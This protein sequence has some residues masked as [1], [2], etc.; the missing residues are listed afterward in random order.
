M[1][2]TFV[3]PNMEWQFDHYSD[4]PLGML[5]VASAAKNISLGMDSVNVSL[6]DMCHDTECPESDVYAFSASTLE[7]PTVVRVA[8][9]ISK[10]NPH[11][12]FIA[13]GPHFDVLS[14]DYWNNEIIRTPF[15]VIS[16]GEGE[17]N[18]ESI[19]RHV[20]ERPFEKKVFSQ[21]GK[22]LNLDSL[23]LPSRNL[24]DKDLYF[25]PGRTFGG[26]D[27]HEKSIEGN[28]S[29]I[30]V[31]RGC[32]YSC[33]F[34]AS[35]TLHRGRVRFRDISKVQEE[36][37][38]LVTDYSV[39]QLRWQDDNIP[40]NFK[41][42]KGLGNILRDFGIISRGSARTDTIVQ[43]PLILNELYSAGF[44]ELGFGIESADQYVL[45]LLDKR[46][47]LAINREALQRAKDAGF[48]T[49]A[50]IMTGL[51]GEDEY[52][53]E[54]MIDFFESLRSSKPDVVTLTSFMPLPGCDIFTNPEKYGIKILSK[55]WGSYSI[56]LS[57][58][59]NPQWT[60]QIPN[61]TSD[62]MDLNREKLKE[63]LFNNNMSNVP[64]YNKPYE[65]SIK[66]DKGK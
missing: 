23:C 2:L 8:E 45:N 10:Q 60:H 40:L 26:A 22:L 58:D 4:P 15:N 62:Q 41:K 36:L 5:S 47:N 51:P 30:M 52:S 18:I 44:R 12:S 48:I 20:K 54:R 50:F 29:T 32:P 11:A 57:R 38:M 65:S 27:S 13:G 19:L 1:D 3:L 28:S 46:T 16:R 24:L 25:K 39:N 55:D 14:E 42:Q 17:A 9:E 33:S 7:F 31:S 34:C 53:A 63:Y 59:D 43:G 61:L 6:F 66:I 56:A 21:Q 64:V 49:R 37:E 35:P